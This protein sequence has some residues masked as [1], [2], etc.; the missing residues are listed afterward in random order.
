MTDHK[1]PSRS[2]TMPFNFGN[3][4]WAL[5]LPF[6][7][8]GANCLGCFDDGLDW[9]AMVRG[10]FDMRDDCFRI[11]RKYADRAGLVRRSD[12][13]IGISE[14]DFQFSGTLILQELSIHLE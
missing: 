11:T 9:A 6:S 5:L 12:P 2:N 8:S 1:V 10:L 3:P 14:V 4:P 13:C 7:L